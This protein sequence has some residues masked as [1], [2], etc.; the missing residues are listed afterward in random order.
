MS[1]KTFPMKIMMMFKDVP[2][3]LR[4]KYMLIPVFGMIITCI[5]SEIVYG[6]PAFSYVIAVA[7]A[8][9]LCHILWILAFLI[10]I[11]FIDW[12]CHKLK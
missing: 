3:Y 2:I 11:K 6:V 4:I 12:I 9:V 1:S 10:P 8:L 7:L 5:I